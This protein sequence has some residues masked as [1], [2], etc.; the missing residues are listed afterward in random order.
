MSTD[1]LSRRNIVAAGAWSVP[2]VALAAATPAAAAS[3]GE[4]EAP[5]VDLVT[6]AALPNEAPDGRGGPSNLRYYQ[7]TR[8]LT[9]TFTYTN[10]GPDDL[11]AGGRVAIDLPLPLSWE[12]PSIIASSQ[13]GRTF[14]AAGT[15][16][17][18]ITQEGSPTIY[19]KAWYF[20]TA[21]PIGAGV[22]ITVTYAITLNDLSNSATDFYKVRFKSRIGVGTSGATEISMA[23]NTDAVP[24]EYVYINR[25]MTP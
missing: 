12:E 13:T 23:N 9:F 8:D 4:P 21:Q 18:D 3:A 16:Q 15:E 11:P 2:I 20:D 19:R 1:K 10:N 14:T 7:G 6:T 5:Q 24:N 17:F 22:S 25:T